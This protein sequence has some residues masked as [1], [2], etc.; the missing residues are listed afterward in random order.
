MGA[1]LNQLKKLLAISYLAPNW[2]EFYKSIVSYLG[3]VLLVE[4]EFQQGKCDPLEDSLLLENQLDIAFI[5]GL[6]FIKHYQIFPLELELLVAPVMQAERYENRPIYFSD[7]IVNT[8]SASAKFEDLEGKMFCYN[9]PGS[10]SGYNLPRYR[11]VQGG[12]SSNFFAKAIQSGSHQRSIRWVIDGKADCAAIDS[13]VLEQ[14][15]RDFPELSDSIRVVETL[16]PS[17]V[18][19]LVVTQRLGVSVIQQ[20]K[21]ALFQPDVEL[22]AAMAKAGVM[23]FASAELRDYELLAKT[24][25][26]D[27]TVNEHIVTG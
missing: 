20:M 19:P 24:L 12:Y 2:F 13:I 15:L 14:E 7:I 4:T 17:P 5:C 26:K 3:R 22:K 6:P 18:P 11:L 25:N 21:L 9:D 23:R 16:G 27:V 10:N 8:K 1:Y